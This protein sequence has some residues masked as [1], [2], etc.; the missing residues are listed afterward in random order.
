[1][2]KKNTVMMAV[3]LPI[4]LKAED[5]HDFDSIQSVLEKILN[6]KIKYEE[7]DTKDGMYRATFSLA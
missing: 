1:M 7:H 2:N 3:T 5:Y 6:T 4:T